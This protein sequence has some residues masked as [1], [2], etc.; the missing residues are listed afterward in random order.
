MKILS[1]NLLFIVGDG[2]SVDDAVVLFG[3]CF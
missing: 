2:G 1:E 3:L